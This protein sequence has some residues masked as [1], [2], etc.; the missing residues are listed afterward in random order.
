[1]QDGVM[2]EG[3]LGRGGRNEARLDERCGLGRL[4]S[5]RRRSEA[6]GR[7][8]RGRC[9]CSSRVAAGRVLECGKGRQDGS[10]DA[11]RQ[12]GQAGRA[13]R[14]GDPPPLSRRSSLGCGSKRRQR[15]HRARPSTDRAPQHT[16]R[17]RP[18]ATCETRR[19]TSSTV[20]AE[21]AETGFPQMAEGRPFV[22]LVA[23]V[24]LATLRDAGR[25]E[26]C[27]RGDLRSGCCGRSC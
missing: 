2:R 19:S 21:A 15:V 12:I 5:M 14:T 23:Q 22:A 18:D 13:A 9:S 27:V 1:M 25:T 7:R 6:G 3:R 16:S 24:V 26:S 4:R 10:L 20:R 17:I 11:F 8:G